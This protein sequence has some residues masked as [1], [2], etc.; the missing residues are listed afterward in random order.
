M[1]QPAVTG[2]LVAGILLGPTVLGL[3]GRHRA[4]IS[5][6]ASTH[7]P[8]SPTL[9]MLQPISPDR[10]AAWRIANGGVPRKPQAADR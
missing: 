8:P 5:G 7:T 2:Q 1:G 9:P 4:H 3:L 10:G 6:E